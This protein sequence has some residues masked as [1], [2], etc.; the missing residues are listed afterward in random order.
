M[1]C[2]ADNS[3]EMSSL[4]SLDYFLKILSAADVTGPLRVNQ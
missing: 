4:I 2:Q 3:H 1:T